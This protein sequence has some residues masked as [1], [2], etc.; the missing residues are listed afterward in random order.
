MFIWNLIRTD[1]GGQALLAV[2]VILVVA[3]PLLN[4]LPV[5]NPL[6]CRPIVSL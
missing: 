3:V 5:D 4:S 1:R 6:P 2:L